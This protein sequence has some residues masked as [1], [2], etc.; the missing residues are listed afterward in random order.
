MYDIYLKNYLDAS[1]NIVA[2]EIKLYSVPISDSDQDKVLVDPTIKTEMGKAGSMDFNIRT[3]FIY[4]N[5]LQQM[6]TLVRV[7]YDG[8]TLFRG[9]ILTIDD[10]HFTGERKVHV[11]GDMT[12][13][14]DSQQPGVKEENR[15]SIS[16]YQHLQNTI[17]E[18]NRQMRVNNE[19]DKVFYLGEVPGNYTNASTSQRITISNDT[20]GNESWR[21]TYDEL[22][23]LKKKY[24]GYFRTRYE[25]NEGK[26]YLDW[27]QTSFRST[28]NNTQPIQV[29]SNMISMN[30]TTEVNNLFT[31]VLPIGDNQGT[32]LYV[33]GYTPPGKATRT[34][35]T[36]TVP[37]IVNFFSDE[38]LNSGFHS[39]SEYQNAIAQ[40]GTIYKAQTFSNAKTQDALWSY[41]IDW[42]KNNYLGG[43]RSFTVSALDLHHID[44]TKQKY[45][46]GDLVSAIYPDQGANTSTKTLV[47]I[48]SQYKLH[49]PD[50]NSYSIGIPSDLIT[51]EYGH[52]PKNNGSGSSSYSSTY[53][54]TLTN[55]VEVYKTV[56][57]YKQLAYDY[58][59]NHRYN[60]DIYDQLM[61]DD[62]EKA[63]RALKMTTLAITAGHLASDDRP[64]S[65]IWKKEIQSMLLNGITGTIKLNGPVDHSHDLT[66]EQVDAINKQNL[67]AVLD[68][69]AFSF[70]MFLPSYD[71]RG[72]V[73]PIPYPNQK[74]LMLEAKLHSD[75]DGGEIDIWGSNKLTN[76]NANKS[77]GLFGIDGSV[78]S[79]LN[80]IGLD[81]EGTSFTTV[82]DGARSLFT[83]LNPLD[84]GSDDP[85]DIILTADGSSGGEI[86]VGKKDNPDPG[87]LKKWM[88][89]LNRSAT[90]SIN[91][92]LAKFGNDGMGDSV[93]TLV[94]GP[95]ANLTMRDPLHAGNPFD[96]TKNTIEL[97]GAS[98]GTG[99]FGKEQDQQTWSI[100]L[101]RPITYIDDQG[102]S[103]TLTKTVHAADFHINEIGSFKTKL[104]VVD[105]LI[106]GKATI[107]QLNAVQVL[108]MDA[109]DKADT[110]M[111]S[112]LWQGRGKIV[113][114]AG[115]F[116]LEETQLGT[117]L[118]VI[119]GGGMSVRS[120][121]VDY[122]IYH[123]GNLTG[124]II[125]DKVNDNSTLTK[126][127]GSRV[128]IEASQV[129]VG[130]TSNVQA[131]MT[132][133][134][135]DIDTLEG[136]VADK[137]TIAQ[138]N[139]Q[140]ARIDSIESDYITT[141]DLET[142]R[143][144]T[145]GLVSTYGDWEIDPDGGAYFAGSVHASGFYPADVSREIGINT[146]VSA[147]V[148][149]TTNTLTLTPAVG[150]PIT[151]SK[152]IAPTLSGSWSS[153][154]FT[155]ASNPSASNSL[156]TS[157]SGSG[158]W[159]IAANNEDVNTY[160]LSIL[161]AIN[162]GNPSATGYTR[163]INAGG[164]YTAGWSGCY[165]TIEIDPSSAT[166]L[167][168][169]DSITVK[170]KAKASSSDTSKTEVATVTVTAPAAPTLSGSW[171]SGVF[172]VSTSPSTSSLTTSLSGSGHWGVAANSEDVNT[173]YLSILGAV[174]SG[175]PSATGYTR[176]IDASGRYTAGYNDGS[177]ASGS[178]VGRHGSGYDWDFN[179]VK[180]DTTSST[181]T[182]N[183]SSI[184]SDARSGYTQGTF[185]AADVTVQGSSAGLCYPALSSGGTVYYAAA[186]AVT[187][188][189]GNGTRLAQV[190][191]YQDGGQ[192][193]V[194]D[195][196]SAATYYR[197][198]G[199]RY[200]QETRYT[201]GSQ[202]FNKAVQGWLELYM[203]V[204][205]SYVSV[206]AGYW[207]T[208]NQ[209][210]E[211]GTIY[212][213]GDSQSVLVQNNS[214]AFYLRGDSVSVEAATNGHYVN[215]RGTAETSYV[216]NSS[217]GYYLRGTAETI[218]PINS[219]SSIRVGAAGTKY[220]AGTRY[221]KNMYYTK[222]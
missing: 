24:G 140:I 69:T 171:S 34:S 44:Q 37:E 218:T 8:T 158:H 7:V 179:I 106:A 114:V 216:S 133:T 15:S 209:N 139:A 105:E 82:I 30:S 145:L 148:N 55:D 127:I 199:T 125:V 176:N 83:M 58:V 207:Y 85:D 26:C 88:V 132:T 5:K 73:R 107:G 131:W 192:A 53:N 76:P 163:E 191:R 146:I 31:I 45:L 48:S 99:A 68:A 63:H 19:E 9:R 59:V 79:V 115:E 89:T 87:E 177:P 222:S 182:I 60:G 6:K 201:S 10:T 117:K 2:N 144:T 25:I 212:A 161:G 186:A 164:R 180:G 124:G 217:G 94:D 195:K 80:K 168:Y 78:N 110:M 170:A 119:S 101:N 184:Y 155:V 173:Y 13:L 14:M 103:H 97:G 64:T 104:A 61:E 57:E 151:F 40:Y 20:F 12:F 162:S 65:G 36:I 211:S 77:I 90:G 116:E 221:N 102:Q 113:G 38:E 178:A 39:K 183:V 136:L 49:N 42:M 126:I 23:E 190:T 27:L 138:L 92:I 11:E 135:Q 202:T 66:D 194:Y 141:G 128:D 41:A 150:D 86:D 210:V 166:T 52:S 22:E 193:L 70:S 167:G 62:P 32:P 203:H 98:N 200:S 71:N 100:T 74:R 142:V 129:R 208:S 214:G 93:T 169:G 206:G 204:P 109:V 153:G 130:S 81:G 175:T 112:A 160:Y 118:K 84:A 189:P 4:Y 174:G 156:V 1:G 196:A 43:I 95:N 187:K 51:K 120:D 154:V 188:Y 21:K 33:E 123:N 56:T 46:T 137:A 134:G 16:I 28:I 122:G 47:I 72:Q 54:G 197:G 157:L 3:N 143:V 149:P 96:R 147:S 18:H 67:F 215:L 159:G 75:L 165:G 185:T 29:T 111:G 152:A 220:E 172:T 213:R 181:L 50:K 219:N 91:S 205:G 121:G 35:K 198:N 17:N 108:A